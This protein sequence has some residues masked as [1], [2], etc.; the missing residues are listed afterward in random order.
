[1]QSVAVVFFFF[2]S[3]WPACEFELPLLLIMSMQACWSSKWCLVYLPF[4]QERVSTKFKCHYASSELLVRR[5][6]GISNLPHAPPPHVTFPTVESD[7]FSHNYLSGFFVFTAECNALSAFK[8]SLTKSVC[9]YPNW[10]NGP[11]SHNSLRW[12]VFHSIASMVR[13]CVARATL[14]QACWHL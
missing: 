6:C 12:Q 13:G 1:M 3:V 4:N 9:C 10:N 7:H 14:F 2:F 8:V 5:P 11:V